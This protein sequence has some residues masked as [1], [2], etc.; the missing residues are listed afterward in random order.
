LA[1]SPQAKKKKGLSPSFGS[2]MWIG[3][4]NRHFV[5]RCNSI[6]ILTSLHGRPRVLRSACLL[7]RL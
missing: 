4:D 5:A 6:A 3:D 1:A 2:F 7:L